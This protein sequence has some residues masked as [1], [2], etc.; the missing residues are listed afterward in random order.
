MPIMRTL[1]RLKGSVSD[2][3][4]SLRVTVRDYIKGSNFLR[5]I[6]PLNH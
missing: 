2:Y 5:Y 3:L 6:F 1:K 4:L